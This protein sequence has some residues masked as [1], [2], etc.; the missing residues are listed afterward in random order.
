MTTSPR[1]RPSTAHPG[2]TRGPWRVLETRE[3]YRNPWI[4]VREDRVVRPDGN[5]GIYGVVEFEPA[6]GVV[7]LTED[8]Q[9]Y[10]VGQYRYATEGY[11]WEVVTGYADPGEDPL[12]SAQRELREEAGLTASDWTPLGHME[13]SNSVTDQ[14]GFLYL[15]RGL[16]IGEPT[17]DGTEELSLRILP[18]AEALRMAQTSEVV[19]AF[20]VAA[21]YRAWHYLRGD[22][23]T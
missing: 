12:A 9:V 23:V 21:L 22:L 18:L 1:R 3:I 5:P 13:I 8:E 14:I 17:P 19:Q 2:Q 15:A 16:T 7:A 6:V 10:L 4:R 11:S 20:S